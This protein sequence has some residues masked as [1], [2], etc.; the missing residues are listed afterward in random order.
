MEIVTFFTILLSPVIAVLITVWLQNRKE[1]RATK[2]WVFNTLIATRH[3]P[4]KDENVRALNM[5][6]VVFYDCSEVRKLWHEYFD[7]LNNQGLNKPNG[8]QARQKKNLEMIKEMARVLG[9]GEAITHLDV[10]RVYYPTGL[11]EQSKR[12]Q[13]ISDELL[14]V[15]KGTQGLQVSKRE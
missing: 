4:I 11:G 6:D 10:D 9:Y 8:W 5:I 12:A 2:L 7:M 15:L 3:D 1:R 14:R 13:E